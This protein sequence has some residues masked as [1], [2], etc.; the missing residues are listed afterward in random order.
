MRLQSSLGRIHYLDHRMDL[1]VAGYLTIA[2]VLKVHHKTGTADIQLLSTKDTIV[3][4]EANE[5]R[6]SARIIQ[7][8]AGFDENR[9]KAWGTVLPITEGS[10]VLVTF[11]DH[12]K[13]RPII[14]GQVPRM[15]NEENVYTPHYPLREQIDGFDRQEAWKHLIVYPSQAYF[16]VDGESNVE[17]AHANKSF[18]TIFSDDKYATFTAEDKHKAFDFDDLSEDFISDLPNAQ[19][20]ANLLYVH[21][22][23]FDDDKTTWTKV[24][25]S[26]DGKLRI[27]RDTNDGTLSYIEV[28]KDGTLRFRRQVDTP[29]H[30]EGANYSEIT[31]KTD[32]TIEL[33]RATE[34]NS[35]TITISNNAEIELNHSSGAHLKMDKDIYIEAA[36]GGEILSESLQ[37]YIEKN[38]IVVS[39]TEP[40]DPQPYLIWIDTSS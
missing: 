1:N 32:G 27:T 26:A 34:E 7:P 25:I 21:R 28:D 8:F 18:F 9:K 36:E 11:L 22:T 29:E 4:S 40:K 5:G 38:Y 14:I 3:S 23:S 37:K 16:K 15:E 12:M 10:Y 13:N 39:D 33:K 17:F 35:A 6:Y 30:G 19:K 31:Q 24:Y 20:P 2:K